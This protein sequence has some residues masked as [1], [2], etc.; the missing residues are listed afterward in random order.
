MGFRD[1]NLIRNDRPNSKLDGGIV[2]LILKN[3]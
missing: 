2:I 3:L 1:Y